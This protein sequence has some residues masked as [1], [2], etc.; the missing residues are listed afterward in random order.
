MAKNR[1][2]GGRKKGSVNKFTKDVKALIL[3]ALA[4]VGGRKYLAAQASENPTAFLG[5][6]GR[7]LPLQ[8]TG[9]D[10]GPIQNKHVVET[11]I[12]DPTDKA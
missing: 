2:T 1:K 9:A 6:V 8:H 10:G 5:L 12:V 4:D 3:G 7:V 11:V